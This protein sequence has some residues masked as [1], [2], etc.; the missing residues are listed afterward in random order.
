MR[1]VIMLGLF[2]AMACFVILCQICTDI[3]RR[4]IY[5]KKG[6]EL[7]A[8]AEKGNIEVVKGLYRIL[9]DKGFN[10]WLDE[11]RHKLG[12]ESIKKIE[13]AMYAELIEIAIKLGIFC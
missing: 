9:G 4:K 3:L 5:A 7:K 1:V 12:E 2:I 11:I 13:Q 10:V 6:E 8:Q